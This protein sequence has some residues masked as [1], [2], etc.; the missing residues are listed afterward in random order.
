MEFTIEVPDAVAAN[1]RHLRRECAKFR[2][3]RNQ[4]RAEAKALRAELEALRARVD[5]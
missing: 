4:A 2:T 5:V 1:I 3:Q